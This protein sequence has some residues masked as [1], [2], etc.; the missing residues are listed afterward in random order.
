MRAWLERYP[1]LAAF[2]APALVVGGGPAAAPLPAG[3]AGLRRARG[4]CCTG[5]AGPVGR[6]SC[7]APRSASASSWPGST[8]S[9]SPSSPMPSASALYAVPAVLGLALFLALHGRRRRRGWWRCAAGA[10]VE[11][12]AL[13]FAVAWTIAEP[14]RGGLGPAVSLEP[15]RLGLGGQ[16]RH[17]AGRG[18]DRHLRAEPAHRGRGRPAAPLFLAGCRRRRAWPSPCPLLFAGAVLAAGALRLAGGARPPDTGVRLRIV[19][20][21]VAAA[22]QMGPRE[23]ARRGSAAIWSCR[24][25]RARPAAAGRDLAGERGALRHRGQPE[26]RD[27]LAPVV[28]P[29][30]ALL[31]GGDRYELERRAADR[32]TTACSS[33]DDGARGAG[34][35]RQG[36]P[37]ARSASSC[38]SAACSAGSACG[39]LTEGSIDFCPGPG[40]V[41][42]QLAGPAAGQPADLLRGRLPRR[43]DRSRAT[44]RPGWST[45]PTTPGSAA[46]PAPT[47]IWPWR[48]CARSRRACRWCA[49][50]TP[51]SR[52]VTDAYGRI[53]AR[54]GLNQTG[55]ID[56]V[57]PGALPEASFARRHAPCAVPG[58]APGRRW[59]L[60][61][62]LNCARP[63]SR[64]SGADQPEP[65]LR[66]R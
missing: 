28:P 24:R 15:G 5:E 31:V 45:S 30:G 10:R 19:Q 66:G 8:G 17:A 6:V 11:A 40:R 35:L 42:L 60:A 52:S 39:K 23:A 18:L 27:Y 65:E 4:R 53:R 48:A 49:R 9:G 58:L 54:L 14:V 25:R 44:G 2:A 20:A 55:V 12:Q 57:L 62:W 47:S 16:R 33:L 43:G 56:A 29:G 59:R 36:R 32:R 51:A 34:P 1:T 7:A 41:T 46:A 63:A 22:P 13:A 26:V 61:Y 38:P 21:N 64:E 37:R 50:P 3:P